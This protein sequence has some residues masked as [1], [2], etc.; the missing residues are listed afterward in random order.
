MI[1][2]EVI[3]AFDCFFFVVFTTTMTVGLTSL[4]WLIWSLCVWTTFD[5]WK[6]NKGIESNWLN[7]FEIAKLC[8]ACGEY[9][10]DSHYHMSLLLAFNILEGGG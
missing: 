2:E 5:R 8:G 6:G 3:N 7:W 10:A 1:R 4:P 9:S